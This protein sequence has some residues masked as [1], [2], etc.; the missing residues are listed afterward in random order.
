[1][2]SII[3]RRDYHL[4]RFRIER[5]LEKGFDNLSQEEM[6]DLRSLSR[7]MSIYEAKHFPAP[8]KALNPDPKN[9][10]AN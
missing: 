3:T 7:Q 6:E 2:Q 10:N 5:Y 4:T 9:R 1:M 8:D